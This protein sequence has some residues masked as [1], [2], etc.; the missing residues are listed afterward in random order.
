[1]IIADGDMVTLNELV[2]LYH[3]KESKEFGYYKLVPWDK[4]S[5]LIAN[6]PSSFCYWKL[7]YF[8]VLVDGWE[9]LSNDFWEDVPR[10]L[11][12]W[13]TPILGVFALHFSLFCLSFGLDRPS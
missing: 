7:R 12:W 2:H 8:F 1:M 3:L 10:L 4:R 5:R 13:E 11:R 6:L 9:T